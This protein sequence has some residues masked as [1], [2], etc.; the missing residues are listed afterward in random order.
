MTERLH[1]TQED[2][3]CWLVEHTEAR[4]IPIY[5]T[6]GNFPTCDPYEALAFTTEEKAKERM[7]EHDHYFPWKPILHGFIGLGHVDN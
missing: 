4:P 7:T 3:Y 1:T 2:M 6:G 5:A